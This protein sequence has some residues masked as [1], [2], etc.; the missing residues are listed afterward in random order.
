[1]RLFID[2]LNRNQDSE[3]NQSIV[4]DFNNFEEIES[5]LQLS[6]QK[7]TVNDKSV[8]NGFSRNPEMV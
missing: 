8:L 6:G 7:L 3:I 1:M 4:R 5:M 2:H